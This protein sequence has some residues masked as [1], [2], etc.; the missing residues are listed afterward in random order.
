VQ[1]YAGRQ[2]PQMRSTEVENSDDL[3]QMATERNITKISTV[4]ATNEIHGEGI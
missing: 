2:K 3:Y 4:T 1:A